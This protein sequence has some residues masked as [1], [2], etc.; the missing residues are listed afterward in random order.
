[1]RMLR[2]SD[3]D[4]S[5]FE[6]LSQLTSAATVSKGTFQSRLRQLR[7]TGDYC[8]LV[9]EDTDTKRIVG[10]GTL[11]V[12][13]KFIRECGSAGHIEDVVVSAA[14]QGKRLGHLLVKK[15]VEVATSCDCYKVLLDCSESHIP[16]YVKCGLKQKGIQ[17]AEYL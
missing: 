2:P 1:M 8:V 14:Y 7:R 5:Y 11:V 16:F 10:S 9:V 15:L 13:H 3:Y 6:L 12:E 4:K 17:M